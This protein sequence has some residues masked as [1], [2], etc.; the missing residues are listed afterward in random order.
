MVAIRVKAVLV[1]YLQDADKQMEKL[2]CCVEEN[3]LEKIKDQ[4]HKMKWAVV[5]VGGEVFGEL[6]VRAEQAVKNNNNEELELLL[7]EAGPKFER[8]K[9]E[10]GKVIDGG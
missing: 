2:W 7:Q 8:L 3:D 6:L 9:Q 4:T 10:V 1:R 5:A